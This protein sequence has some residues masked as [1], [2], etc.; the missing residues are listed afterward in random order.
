MIPGGIRCGRCRCA[1]RW[2][3]SAGARA[4]RSSAQGRR[5]RQRRR[6]RAARS[7]CTSSRSRARAARQAA[8]DLSRPGALPE[9]P[10]ERCA[11]A[12][13]ARSPRRRGAGAGARAARD[14]G[15]LQ[16]HRDGERSDRH[17]RHA[18]RELDVV[19]GPRTS[20]ATSRSRR[21]ARSRRAGR[22]D[23]PLARRWPSCGG[24]GRCGRASRSA[25]RPGTTR[26]TRRSHSCAP[27]AIRRRPGSAPRRRSTR[28]TA[29]NLDLAVDSGPLFRLGAIPSRA[30]SATT[31]TRCAGSPPSR[32]ARRT[33]RSC[34]STTRSGWR[35]PACSRAHRS[36]SIPIPP[37]RGGAGHR[38]GQG[39][40]PAQATLGVGYSAN[41]G[42]RVTLEHYHRQVFGTRWIAH[43]KF[44]VGPD[45]KSFGTEFTPYP[46][47][48][49]Y[50]NLVAGNAEHLRSVEESAP[51][52]ARAPGRPGHRPH[53]APV[54]PR[55]GAR[56]GRQR[57]AL[58]QQRRRHRA[59]TSGCCATSTTSCC[60]PGDHT[61]TQ[62]ALGYGRDA[63]QR[64]DGPANDRAASGPFT[65]A[66]GR[67]TWYK[68]LGGPGTERR[69][70]VG[71]VFAQSR[72]GVPDPLLFRAGGDD[73][74]RGYGY[75]TLGPDDQRRSHQRPRAVTGE[76]GGRA[77]DLDRLPS[78][79]WAPSSMPATRPIAGS[80]SSGAR[81]RRR[82]ALAQSGRPAA[83][84]PGLRPG[85][86]PGPT[87]PERRHRVLSSERERR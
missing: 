54:L 49:F 72:I 75:R 74:V 57:P 30:S 43:N 19:P 18:A 68:P 4:C 28:A 38:E 71:E 55:G 7:R 66:Y 64:P 25:R 42:P 34:C 39:A 80:T 62:G 16:R 52:G 41:T 6:G 46:L 44:E 11:D 78:V 33:A 12:R 45:L 31:P 84:R 27:T 65:R 5:G 8:R 58:D 10:R 26:R 81:L 36:R 14:R 3:C 9:A 86:A 63:S 56:A 17:Q 29:A 67:L 50:R 47:E 70:E 13:R 87:A 83:R 85:R 15:L 21:T 76:R 51:R 2:P 40:A 22:G 1:S 61:W 60:R 79:W 24:S 37:R 59:T 20:S 73:S 32:P 53:R 48:N 77:P 69:G 23:E 82:P 35:R